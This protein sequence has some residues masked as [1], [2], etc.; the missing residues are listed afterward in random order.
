M[1]HPGLRIKALLLTSETHRKFKVDH[2]DSVHF[3]LV[4]SVH[5]VFLI[6]FFIFG[7]CLA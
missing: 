1:S 4:F 5:C 2:K 6:Y 3:C 7:Q